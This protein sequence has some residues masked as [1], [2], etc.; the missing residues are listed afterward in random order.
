[1]L[2]RFWVPQYLYPDNSLNTFVLVQRNVKPSPRKAPNCKCLI[3]MT[4][5]R[6]HPKKTLKILAGT[7]MNR[8]SYDSINF[9][10]V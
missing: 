3:L 4:C 6:V 5:Q 1:M 9:N 2:S 7:I 8:L 10:E